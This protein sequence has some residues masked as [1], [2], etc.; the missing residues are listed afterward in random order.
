MA[1]SS[2]NNI[3]FLPSETENTP[4]LKKLLGDVHKLIAN[5]LE[6]HPE[7]DE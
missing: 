2:D 3:S 4:R 5:Y 6:E 1:T 7:A